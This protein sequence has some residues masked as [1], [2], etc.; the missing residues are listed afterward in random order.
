MNTTI[1]NKELSNSKAAF[2]VKEALV[3]F[4]LTDLDEAIIQYLSFLKTVVPIQSIYGVHVVPSMELYKSLF[5]GD[6]EEMEGLYLMNEE[7]IK[8]IKKTF[9]KVMA[10]D[11]IQFRCDA[12]E[13]DPLEELLSR[14]EETSPDLVVIG[15]RQ[16]PSSFGILPKNLI[17]KSDG[18]VLLVPEKSRR[19]LKTIMVPIDFSENSARALQQAINIASQMEE[20][21]RILATHVYSMPTMSVYQAGKTV[22]QFSKM[23]QANIED[24][25]QAFINKYNDKG[26]KVETRL[27]EQT[28]PGISSYLLEKAEAEAAD[29]IVMG[30]KGHS[31][32]ELLLLGSVTEKL[33][34]L[35]NNIPV[36]V[37]R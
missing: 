7:I 16:N 28:L 15:K 33:L 27:I 37:I 23:I 35:D 18:N 3:G 13:G 29:M 19:Q 9:D 4:D 22:E 8:S 1:K 26:V 30:V 17:R 10:D 25:F 20:K 31:K 36:L 34:N 24:A 12:T 11:A 14:A 21:P 5:F 32:V 6:S 2:Q